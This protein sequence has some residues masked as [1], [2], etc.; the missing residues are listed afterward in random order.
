M[1]LRNKTILS[2]YFNEILQ[3]HDLLIK[4][5]KENKKISEKELNTYLSL[6]LITDHKVP[7]KLNVVRK[8]NKEMVINQLRNIEKINK[9]VMVS[10]N[11]DLNTW[12]SKTLGRKESLTLENQ[13]I[14]FVTLSIYVF[15]PKKGL[16]GIDKEIH[17]L[18]I[19]IFLNNGKDN[20]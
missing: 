10:K 9:N 2:K 12:L 1:N 6:L 15:F 11:M 19:E 16:I 18:I 14:L 8:I 4:K 20:K 3:T 13:K 5:I 17:P 7:K